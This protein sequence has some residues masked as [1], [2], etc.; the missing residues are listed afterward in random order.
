MTVTND[1][2]RNL[3]INTGLEWVNPEEQPDAVGNINDNTL[4]YVLYKIKFGAQ[5]AYDQVIDATKHDDRWDEIRFGEE[6]WDRPP[7]VAPGIVYIPVE[8]GDAIVDGIQ[9]LRQHFSS[10]Y[11]SNIGD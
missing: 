4:C 8:S 11:S 3:T 7:K 6:K 2:G 5:E 10:V 9:S 1:E